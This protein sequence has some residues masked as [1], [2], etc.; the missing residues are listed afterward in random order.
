MTIIRLIVMLIAMTRAALPLAVL[1]AAGELAAAIWSDTCQNAGNG[2]GAM[3][4]E[5]IQKIVGCRDPST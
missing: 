3:G 4:V 5:S 1:A 2:G